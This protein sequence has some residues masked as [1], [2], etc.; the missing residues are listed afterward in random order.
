MRALVTTALALREEFVMRL[1]KAARSLQR[2]S[3]QF[4]PAILL[5]ILLEH[6]TGKEGILMQR[7]FLI[8]MDGVIYRGGELI[9][10]AAEFIGQLQAA[11]VPF[12]FL[13]NN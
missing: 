11:Q 1:G 3:H 12:T 8:D 4:A 9:P 7:G 2:C 13:T 6:F 5:K 10:G